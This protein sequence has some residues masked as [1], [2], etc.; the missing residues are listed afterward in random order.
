MIF[1]FP[2]SANFQYSDPM[3]LP[4][5]CGE[6]GVAKITEQPDENSETGKLGI[7]ITKTLRQRHLNEK[8]GGSD[9]FQ[10]D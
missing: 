1:V 7:A 2:F 3:A 5:W 6:D 4:P 10:Q 9:R 8:T